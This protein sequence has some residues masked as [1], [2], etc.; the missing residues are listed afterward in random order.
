MEMK[1]K[2]SCFLR[3]IFISFIF[4]IIVALAALVYYYLYLNYDEKISCRVTEDVIMIND[5]H[6]SMY[7]IKT[8]D[9]YIVVDAGYFNGI[10]EKG[11]EYNSIDPKKINAVLLTHT[12]FD[13]QGAIDIFS[14]ATI[15]LSKDEYYMVKDKENRISFVPYFTN[16]MNF[17]NYILLNDGDELTIGERKIKCISLPG[18]TRGSMGFIIDSKYLFS[19]DAFRIKN[20]KLQLPFKKF[21]TMDVLKMENS[22]RKVA[23][24]EGIKYIFSGHSGFTADFDYAV[25][26]WKLP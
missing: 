10:I 2:K 15:Y 13:H 3:L 12:D 19:G 8:K 9:S 21:F 26:D 1:K 5:L 7:L 4:L 6:S 20:G 18:H 11:L 24:L 16:K 22:L 25:T 14:N 17:K 23:Q